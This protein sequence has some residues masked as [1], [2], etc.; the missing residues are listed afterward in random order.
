MEGVALITG[1]A[2]GIGAACAHAFVRKGVKNIILADYQRAPLESFEA[3]LRM[4]YPDVQ[5]LGVH[6]DVTDEGAV[7]NMM[8]QAVARFG[9]VDYAVNSAGITNKSKVGEYRTEDWDRVINVNQRGVFLCMRAELVQMTKQ[10]LKVTPGRDPR[11]GQRGAI[12]NICS[13]NSY[14]AARRNSAYV[15]SKHAVLG[16]TRTCGLDYAEERIRCNGVAPGYVETPI[17]LAP[18]N[19]DVLRESTKPSKTPAGR[20][21]LPEEIAEVVTFLC[22]DEASYVNGSVWEVDGGFLTI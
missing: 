2:S 9:G 17:T 14:V 22:S 18:Q 7:E 10:D 1:G 4:M 20:P 15:S 16:L 19:I 6:C 3:E 8:A 13:I 21:G 5:V 11:R 12:V